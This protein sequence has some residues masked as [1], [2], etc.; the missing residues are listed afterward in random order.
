MTAALALLCVHQAKEP[1][2]QHEETIMRLATADA[3][4]GIATITTA[5]LASCTA[6][7]VGMLA[8]MTSPAME[9]A[10]AIPALLLA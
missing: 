1:G 9:T 6:W 2:L 4:K 7:L 10:H 3:I 8:I 5:A